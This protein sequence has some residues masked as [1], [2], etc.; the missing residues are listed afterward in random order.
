[1]VYTAIGESVS[2][3]TRIYTFR[4]E[5]GSTIIRTCDPAL[6]LFGVGADYT[7]EEIEQRCP[8]ANQ[9]G[10]ALQPPY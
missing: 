9:D 8:G 1:V 3:S 7:I 2:Q 5:D 4:G 10:G 6:S